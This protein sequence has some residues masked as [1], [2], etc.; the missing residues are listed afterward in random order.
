VTFR[1]NIS[2]PSSGLKENCFLFF[3]MLVSCLAYSS[4]LKME[5]LCSSTM[6]FDFIRLH[7]VIS[8]KTELFKNHISVQKSLQYLSHFKCKPSG[9][10]ITWSRYNSLVSVLLFSSKRMY[11]I[12]IWI[13]SSL[14][15]QYTIVG[16]QRYSHCCERVLQS[17]VLAT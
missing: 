7:R 9:T 4:I 15:V 12:C 14:T 1:G 11:S 10:T 2:S 6:S 13:P 8:H 5:T 3:F 17:S 16:W